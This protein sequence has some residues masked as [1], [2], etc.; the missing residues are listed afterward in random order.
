MEL[1]LDLF[2]FEKNESAIQRAFSEYMIFFLNNIDI[3]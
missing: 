1:A 3:F 2:T